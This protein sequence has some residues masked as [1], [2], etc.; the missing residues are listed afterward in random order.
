MTG[1]DDMT[2]GTGPVE[3]YSDPV[4]GYVA[5]VRLGQ[6]RQLTARQPGWGTRALLAVTDAWAPCLGIVSSVAA[7][8]AAAGVGWP[9]HAG[10]GWDVHLRA[11]PCTGMPG[12]ARN[13]SD[14][15]SEDQLPQAG[16]WAQCADVLYAPCPALPS[17]ALAR[18]DALLTLYPGSLLVCV[19]LPRGAGCVVAVRAGCSL[20]ARAVPGTVSRDQ[21][22]CLASFLHSWL[23]SGR[24][25]S[26][27]RT[28]WIGGGLVDEGVGVRDVGTEVSLTVRH[29]C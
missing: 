27:L 7:A 22:A 5:L 16:Q 23:V 3:R 2:G 20:L 4:T 11:E 21:V 18:A 15:D 24:P 17:K 13:G 9:L 12:A 8:A 6:T 19:P 1:S 28:V 25:V 29:A 10:E 14:P 26:T